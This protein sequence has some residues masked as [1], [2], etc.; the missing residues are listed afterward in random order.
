MKATCPDCGCQGHINAFLLEE[1]GKRLAITVAAMPPE[2]GRAVLA[3]LGLFKPAK[4]G[5]RMARAVKLAQEVADLVAAGTVCK[6]ERGG[7]RRPAQVRH[8]VAAIDQMLAARPKLTLPLESHGYLRAV[9]FGLADQADALAE[10][11]REEH[12]RAGR[13]LGTTARVNPGAGESRLD[14]RL[15][16]ISQMVSL[17][18]MSEDDAERERAEAREKY[19]ER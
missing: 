7:I 15:A 6:D 4:Q 17:G 3:Y 12:V 5:L 16:W 9:V 2:L 10:R 19:G 13:H 18:Q 8:W 1:E 11:E 14:Q